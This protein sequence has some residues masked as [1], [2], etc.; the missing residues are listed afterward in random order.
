M[1]QLQT[2]ARDFIRALT[3]LSNQATVVG[4]YGD[5]GSGKTTFTQAIGRAL[6]ITDPMQSPTFVLIKQYPLPVSKRYTLNAIRYLIHVDAY[7]LKN[8]DE[9]RNLCFGELLAD[10][11]NLIFVEW[12]DRVVDILPENH[13]K[14]NFRFIDEKTREISF[15]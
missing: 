14:L 11:R 15:S 6:G 5:L 3:P 13:R 9:L 4:L 2:A 7:R 1:E 10:P 8:S 12:A